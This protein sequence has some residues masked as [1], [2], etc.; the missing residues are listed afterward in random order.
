MISSL[1]DTK[2]YFEN[3][4]NDNWTQ[5]P[6]HFVGQVETLHGPR[7]WWGISGQVVIYRMSQTVTH[8][9]F[10]MGEGSIIAFLSC[11]SIYR[12]HTHTTIANEE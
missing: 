3:L 11:T 1:R 5:T 2:L 6:I 10:S 12:I 9:V 4:F 7:W 8:E